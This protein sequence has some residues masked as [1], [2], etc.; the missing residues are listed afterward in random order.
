MACMLIF[1]FY[2]YSWRDIYVAIGY[3]ITLRQRMQM[4]ILF[5]GVKTYLV[6]F[7]GRIDLFHKM[8]T[9]L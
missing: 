9:P 1:A 2:E 7:V 4:H 6:G 8:I 3:V 5:T